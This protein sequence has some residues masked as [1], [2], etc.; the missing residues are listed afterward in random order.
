[1]LLGIK[2]PSLPKDVIQG[3]DWTIMAIVC[4]NFDG[5]F[6]LTST[7]FLKSFSMLLFNSASI[8]F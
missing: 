6:N 1:M 3:I 2:T 7:H 8:V 4:G 5:G